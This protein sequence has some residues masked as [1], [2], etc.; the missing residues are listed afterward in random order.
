MAKVRELHLNR[1]EIYRSLSTSTG[2]SST[3]L[4]LV[5][6]AEESN[7]FKILTLEKRSPRGL[8]ATYGPLSPALNWGSTL[9]GTPESVGTAEQFLRTAD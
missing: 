1:Q 3:T 4:Y 6:K 8:V 9:P 5:M 2:I 7:D